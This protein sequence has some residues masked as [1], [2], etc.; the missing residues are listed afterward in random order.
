MLLVGISIF[1]LIA[2]KAYSSSFTHDESYSYL[3]YI[4]QPFMDIL[5]YKDSYTNNH[6]LNSL[7][8][9]YSENLFGTSEFALRLPNLLLFIGYSLYG[10]FILKNNHKIITVSFVIILISNTAI[11]DFFGLARGYGL[12]IGFMMMAIYYLIKSLDSANKKHLILFHLAALLATLSNFTL[13]NFYLAAMATFYGIL[14]IESHYLKQSRRGMTIFKN[15]LTN[16]FMCLLSLIVLYEP[17][18]RLLTFNVLDF[19]G[20]A[21]FIDDT[22]HFISSFLFLGIAISNTELV[23]LMS[24]LG[25]MLL[26]IFGLIIKM[27]IQKQLLFFQKHKALIVVHSL[28]LLIFMA[29]IIQHWLFKTDY[30]TGRFAL[31]LL[32]LM[33]LNF[34]F[35]SHYLITRFNNKVLLISIAFIALLSTYRFY[36]NYSITSNA[37]WGYDSNTKK[38][39]EL[40][41]SEY[42]ET[43][44]SVSIGVSWQFEPT[45][46]FYRTM[47][48][49]N[50]VKPIERYALNKP[51]NYYLLS[52]TDLESI[53]LFNHINYEC[54]AYYK[55]TQTILLKAK[56]NVF[57]KGTAFANGHGN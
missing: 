29:S 48:K 7:M 42:P 10:F 27:I 30:L 40:I 35:L 21:G 49:L 3:H 37:E 11:N 57:P 4:P 41:A 15:N 24:T 56:I 5:S 17:I 8:M 46:N 43:S 44:D 52:I 6:I 2:I 45:T 1:I 22:F 23:I 19:G 31:F 9:K 26:F 50:W 51:H 54:L 47:W 39:M 14:M 25:L 20:K 32:P 34:A 28:L 16:W 55:N 36:Y 18:R 38:A 33:L 53:Q 12:S 13:L